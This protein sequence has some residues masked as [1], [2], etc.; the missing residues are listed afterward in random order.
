[1]RIPKLNTSLRCP[2]SYKHDLDNRRTSLPDSS[3][4]SK[5]TSTFN[6][7][8][9]VLKILF[10]RPYCSMLNSDTTT[11][12]S[13][14]TNPLGL[15][16]IIFPKMNLKP[17]TKYVL[18]CFDPFRMFMIQKQQYTWSM[19]SELGILC[20]GR[21]KYIPYYLNYEACLELKDTFSS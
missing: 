13:G 14:R 18:F 4:V 5:K 15:D 16:M 6:Y 21:F 11:Q 7:I 9:K 10:Q 2:H 1:M 20:Y 19:M 3:N 17:I 8:I 12:T